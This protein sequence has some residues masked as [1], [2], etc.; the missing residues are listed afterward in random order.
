MTTG[1]EPN[2]QQLAVLADRS[3][4]VG[5][6]LAGALT[7]VC[8]PAADA[9]TTLAELA[10]RDDIAVIAVHGTV[11][12]RLPRQVKAEWARRNT[13]LVLALPDADGATLA[14][15]QAELSDLLLR[16]VGFQITF[17]PGDPDSLPR[18]AARSRERSR[19]SCLRPGGRRHRPAGC[20]HSRRR[21]GGR[22]SAA[23]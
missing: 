21:S 16:A 15:H 18:F 3:A 5:F 7:V 17:E 9:A 8:E 22:C 2:V 20:A 6:R 11:W 13:P 1:R 10:D 19:H 14:A 12:A 23:R 4:A